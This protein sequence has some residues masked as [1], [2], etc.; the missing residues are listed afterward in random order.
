MYHIAGFV[1]S[2]W[3]R[4]GSEILYK[5]IRKCSPRLHEW[6]TYLSIHTQFLAWVV[7]TYTT[8]PT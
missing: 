1:F 2:I 5:K 7:S 4:V 3:L 8:Y 6:V